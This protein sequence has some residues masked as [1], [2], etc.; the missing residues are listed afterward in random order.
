MREDIRFT[1]L[2][3]GVPVVLVLLFFAAVCRVASSSN[4][5]KS[6][7]VLRGNRSDQEVV[8]TMG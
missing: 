7:A 8:C 2:L 3:L 6:M 4:V 5:T 1:P